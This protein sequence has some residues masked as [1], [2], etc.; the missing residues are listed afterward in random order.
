MTRA[1]GANL[2]TSETLCTS[3][4]ITLGFLHKLYKP[5]RDQLSSAGNGA[6][7]SSRVAKISIYLLRACIR[8]VIAIVCLVEH[9][10]RHSFGDGTREAPCDTCCLALLGNRLPG[11][12]E[13]LR[14]EPKV[15]GIHHHGGVD[16]DSLDLTIARREVGA[17]CD[18]VHDEAPDHLR[19]L[20]DRDER[21]NPLQDLLQGLE[22]EGHQAEVHV[23]HRVHE[24]PM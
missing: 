5:E 14:E 23:H 18:A 3:A 15:R 22:L 11:L 20:D 6:L 24:V 4:T 13:E 10:L 2:H 12:E 19:D 17:D 9:R 8:C 7:K 21:G 1:A 16:R